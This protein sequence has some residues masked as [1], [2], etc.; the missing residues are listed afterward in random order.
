M[1]ILGT[2]CKSKKKLC[3]ENCGEQKKSVIGYL[4][5]KTKCQKTDE[6]IEDMKIECKLCGSK[7]LPVSMTMHMKL[8]HT[9][10]PESEQTTS[11]QAKERDELGKGRRSAKRYG[12]CLASVN[13]ISE[14]PFRASE[15]INKIAQSE[16]ASTSDGGRQIKRTAVVQK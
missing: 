5:H 2:V 9:K 4:S 12:S 14:F 6:E 8:L 16:T 15:L 7:M 13:Y 1:S 11:D 10:K 3:C